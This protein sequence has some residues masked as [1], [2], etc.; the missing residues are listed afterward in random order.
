MA[1]S[2]G[3]LSLQARCRVPQLWVQDAAHGSWALQSRLK[4]SKANAR[5]H[6]Q[7]VVL[8]LIDLLHCFTHQQ[9]SC[10]PTPS[11]MPGHALRGPTFSDS[12]VESLTDR[13]G[14][15]RANSICL[16]LST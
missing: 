3:K 7:Q 2:A 5:L 8:A 11:F 10:S 15:N 14:R 12:S 9:V 4:G 6:A 1:G 13:I 16:W